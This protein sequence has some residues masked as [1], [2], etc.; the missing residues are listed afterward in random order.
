MKIVVNFWDLHAVGIKDNE[1]SIYEKIK[2]GIKLE[3]NRY[4][5][6]LPVKEF[7]PILPDNYLLS[8]NRCY[9]CY[10]SFPVILYFHLS[11]GNRELVKNYDNI[12]QE[13]LQAGI[14]EKVHHE[15]E[16]GDI[17]IYHSRKL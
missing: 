17:H 2:D 15:G 12:F 14:I 9:R 4:S 7:H 5:V 16:C 6:K 3:N 11:D 8:L 13:Q 10:R 1:I